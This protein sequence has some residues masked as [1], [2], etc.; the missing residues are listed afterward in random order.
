VSTAGPGLN[1]L[2]VVVGSLGR[3][4]GEGEA[5]PIPLNIMS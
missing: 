1:C 5:N 3:L 4:T 2:K